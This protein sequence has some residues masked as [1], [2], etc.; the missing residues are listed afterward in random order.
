MHTRLIFFEGPDAA[1]LIALRERTQRKQNIE[2]TGPKSISQ[3]N[4]V[5]CTTT[6]RPTTDSGRR[7]I[8]H[9]CATNATGNDAAR[10]SCCINALLRV[11]SPWSARFW[12][13][14]ID[15]WLADTAVR[16]GEGVDLVS[17]FSAVLERLRGAS[18]ACHQRVEL[19]FNRVLALG[20]LPLIN[21]AGPLVMIRIRFHCAG[22]A[23]HWCHVDVPV[24]KIQNEVHGGQQLGPSHDPRLLSAAEALPVAPWT[25]NAGETMLHNEVTGSPTFNATDELALAVEAATNVCHAMLHEVT[26]RGDVLRAFTMHRKHGRP[27]WVVPMAKK[28]QDNLPKDKTILRC[29]ACHA[30]QKHAAPR[31]ADRHDHHR[32]NEDKPIVT[33]RLNEL[34]TC[35]LARDLEAQVACEM[36]AMP[37]FDPNEWDCS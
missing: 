10:T 24:E 17:I 27:V 33:H 35:E 15:A 5:A 4:L 29:A 34:V 12:V 11:K 28:P 1:L 25:C 16:G 13:A 20:P 21:D 31:F 32:F 18:Q 37:E 19:G 3:H 9:H 23:E 2:A 22:R 14:A 30:R 26:P 6:E 7:A 8:H 36:A